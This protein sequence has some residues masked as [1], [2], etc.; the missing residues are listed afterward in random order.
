MSK[1]LGTN[2]AAPVV[3]FDTQD[4]YPT[5]VDEYGK[6]GF[7]ALADTAARDAIPVGRLK[8]GMLVSTADDKKV[9]RLDALDPVTWTEFLVGG[10]GS[11]SVVGFVFEQSSPSTTWTIAHNLGYKPVVSLYSVGS[12]EFEGQVTHLS[13][14]VCV[15]NLVTAMAGFARCV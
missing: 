14:N 7:V 4:V 2:I 15:V 10:G 13:S 9:W 6:G 5:H 1:I 8:I 3:P 12:V 11:G